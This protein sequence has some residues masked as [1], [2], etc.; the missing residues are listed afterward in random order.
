MFILSLDQLIRFHVRVYA[1]TF[2]NKI[3]AVYFG[4]LALARLAVSLASAFARPVAFV[5][6][7]PIPIDA[8]N[9]CPVVPNLQF[10]LVPNAIGTAF[11]EWVY[12]PVSAAGVK[13]R[14]LLNT[15]KI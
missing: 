12:V 4:T 3:L 5:D 1:I 2:K 7:P 14:K 11:G 6:L 9:F 15:G 10:K 13:S 8:F